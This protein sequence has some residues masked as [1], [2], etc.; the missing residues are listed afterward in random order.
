M[1]NICIHPSLHISIKCCYHF[2]ARKLI[3]I[4]KLSNGTRNKTTFIF[5]LIFQGCHICCLSICPCFFHCRL[6]VSKSKKLLAFK[7]SLMPF[8]YSKRPWSNLNRM[9]L[10]TFHF[11]ICEW[12]VCNC[13]WHCAKMFVMQSVN[14][15]KMEIAATVSALTSLVF[16]SAVQTKWTGPYENAILC[17]SFTSNDR[18]DDSSN[19]RK[20]ATRH[21]HEIC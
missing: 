11:H 19:E 7:F 21:T 18:R 16:G 20:N 17:V 9:H 2:R 4:V 10:E 3:E 6:N 12:K 13:C 1:G 14:E 8:I 15:Q 5:F